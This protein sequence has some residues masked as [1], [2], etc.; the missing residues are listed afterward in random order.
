MNK[1]Y[2][3]KKKTS[4]T[5]WQHVTSILISFMK[6]LV[7]LGSNMNMQYNDKEIDCSA[8]EDVTLYVI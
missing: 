6:I 7:A 4:F 2:N 1:I 8:T 3:L 5:I